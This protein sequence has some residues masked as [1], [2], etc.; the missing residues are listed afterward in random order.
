MRALYLRPNQAWCIVF[1]D[2]LVSIEDRTL[3]PT[4]AD[5]EW[6]LRLVGLQIGRGYEI[7]TLDQDR[8]RA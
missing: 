8:P 2:S 6:S 5:L 1:G 7:V 3:W 4:L